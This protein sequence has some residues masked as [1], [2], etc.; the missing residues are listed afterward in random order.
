MTERLFQSLIGPASIDQLAQYG[1]GLFGMYSPIPGLRP[2][3]NRPLPDVV[4]PNFD[5]ILGKL[6]INQT[7]QAPQQA[8]A[9]QTKPMQPISALPMPSFQQGTPFVPQTGPAM[10]H[11]GEAVIPAHQNPNAQTRATAPAQPAPP[12]ANPLQQSIQFLQQQLMSGGPISPQV[13][14]IQ[15]QQLADTVSMGQQQALNDLRARMGG[16]G[17]GG[18]GLQFGIEQNIGND[19]M[20]ALTQ[21]QNQIALDAAGRNYDA[22]GNTANSL[23]GNA[24]GA[25]QFGLQQAAFNMNQSQSMLDQLMQMIRNSY[26]NPAQQAQ[27]TTNVA[28]V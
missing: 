26:A 28:F 19:A 7:R 15:N 4:A 3:T 17:L 27:N 12:A 13:Q 2:Q 11:Q 10:L 21:G 20:R 8:P 5:D 6:G 22:L 14:N 23:A 24:L 25:G 16:R 1:Q 9:T 18:S